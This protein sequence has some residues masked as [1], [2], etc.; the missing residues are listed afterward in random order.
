MQEITGGTGTIDTLNNSSVIQQ[1]NGGNG[2][3]NNFSA[4]LQSVTSGGYRYY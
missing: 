3:I 1:V 2:V 4:G